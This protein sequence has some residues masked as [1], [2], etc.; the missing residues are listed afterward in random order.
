V[1][2]EL[3]NAIECVGAGQVA[4]ANLIVEHFEFVCL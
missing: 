3:G 2:R 4:S 1:P